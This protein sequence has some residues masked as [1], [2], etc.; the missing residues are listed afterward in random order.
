TDETYQYAKT[1]LDLMTREKDKRGKILLI[2]GGIANFTDVAKTF[3]GIT[4]ALEEYRQN[5]IDNKI[6]IYVRRGGPNYQMGLEK[7]KELGKKLGV[8]IEVF[9][10]E[11]HMTSIVPMGLAKK[12]RV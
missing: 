12:T 6:K 1:I 3:T 7:M 11:E 10:P 2:G 5:L 4:K 9:G 8:P